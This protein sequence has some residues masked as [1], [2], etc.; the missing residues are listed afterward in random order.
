MFLELLFYP[1][2]IIHEFTH[3]LACVLLGVKVTKVKFGLKESYVQHLD[4]HN[5]KTI[6]IALAPFILSNIISILLII[7]TLKIRPAFYIFAIFLW[8]AITVAYHSAPSRKDIENVDKKIISIYKSISSKN[9]LLQLP[10]LILN[11]ILFIPLKIFDF[12]MILFNKYPLLKIILIAIV[13]Q[14][15]V[16]F[17]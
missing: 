7:Y 12:I 9:I 16:L 14:I 8:I 5:W 15:S 4:V 3:F 11:T 13:F 10:I 6:L 1:G 2:V 17:L